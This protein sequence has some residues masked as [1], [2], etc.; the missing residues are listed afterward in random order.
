MWLRTLFIPVFIGFSIEWTP[1]WSPT[2]ICIDFFRFDSLSLI[3]R[4]NDFV[5]SFSGFLDE[6]HIFCS[7]FYDVG[8]SSFSLVKSYFMNL[9]KVVE[10][11]NFNPSG[12]TTSSLRILFMV[13]EWYSDSKGV[14]PV[15]SLKRVTPTAHKST[16]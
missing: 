10:H 16:I 3:E 9:F 4:V 11:S 2:P 6:N 1:F 5:S 12:K 15:T 7:A 14:Y 13:S 8:L